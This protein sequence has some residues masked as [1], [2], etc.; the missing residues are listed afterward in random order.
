MVRGSVFDHGP[1]GLVENTPP[2]ELELRE[3]ASGVGVVTWSPEVVTSAR[4]IARD[5]VPAGIVCGCVANAS[6]GGDHGRN[7]FQASVR[8][9]PS[10]SPTHHW[11][12]P[13]G[14]Q[15]PL[16]GSSGSVSWAESRTAAAGRSRI[17]PLCVAKSAADRPDAFRGAQAN[18]QWSWDC[19]LVVLKVRSAS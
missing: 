10:R 17:W 12:W 5:G 16:P 6:T 1:V 19:P 8:R 7:D 3:T 11:F 13:G 4:L 15:A 2:G 18:P 9:A 14:P